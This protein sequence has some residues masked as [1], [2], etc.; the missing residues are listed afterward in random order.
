MVEKK[1]TEKTQ[2]KLS[3][4]LDTGIKDHQENVLSSLKHYYPRLLN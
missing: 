4:G 2:Y 3:I 1:I